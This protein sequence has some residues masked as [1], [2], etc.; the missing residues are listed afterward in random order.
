[1][2]DIAVRFFDFGA[3]LLQAL[4][5]DPPVPFVQAGTYTFEYTGVINDPKNVFVS[6]ELDPTIPGGGQ[7]SPTFVTKDIYTLDQSELLLSLKSEV[8][9]LQVICRHGPTQST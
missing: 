1:L 3:Q 4:E 7:D 5:F 6:A 8:G 2:S 9:R